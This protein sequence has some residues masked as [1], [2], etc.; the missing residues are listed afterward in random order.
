[1]L[2]FAVP[3][4]LRGLPKPG[5]DYALDGWGLWWLRLDDVGEEEALLVEEG[6]LVDPVAGVEV[7]G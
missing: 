5:F 1:M 3:P 2:E 6:G 4:V 7:Q